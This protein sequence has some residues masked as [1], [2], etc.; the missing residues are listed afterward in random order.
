MTEDATTAFSMGQ[1]WSDQFPPADPIGF[2]VW[3]LSNI[4]G[5]IASYPIGSQRGGSTLTLLRALVGVRSLWRSDKRDLA[6]G[7]VAVVVLGFT[8]ALLRKYPFG[9]CRLNQHLAPVFCLLGGIGAATTLRR[10]GDPRNGIRSAS[11]IA[12]ILLA[13]GLIG[14]GRDLLRPWR[15]SQAKWARESADELRRRVAGKAILRVGPST[16]PVQTWYLWAYGL[17]SETEYRGADETWVLT[18]WMP[19]HEAEAKARSALPDGDWNIV[20]RWRTTIPDLDEGMIAEDTRAFH[21][22]RGRENR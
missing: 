22:R 9:S 1:Y 11:I 7:L 12:G 6:I 20:E 15:D 5:E 3:F 16:F 13:I 2:V 14:L 18:F 19:L 8:A 4:A 21:F 17:L 10:F